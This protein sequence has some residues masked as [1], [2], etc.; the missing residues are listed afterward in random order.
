M[1]HTD[2]NLN[3]YLIGFIY[4]SVD[5]SALPGTPVKLTPLRGQ[6]VVPEARLTIPRN[7]RIDILPATLSHAFDIM[8][9]G[10]FVLDCYVWPNDDSSIG[11]VTPS[12]V[13][14]VGVLYRRGILYR[15]RGSVV[16]LQLLLLHALPTV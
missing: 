4:C 11:C 1:P 14:A 9:P 5:Q 13:R 3:F 10:R 16:M 6:S 8:S 15:T 2:T 12:R 7:S